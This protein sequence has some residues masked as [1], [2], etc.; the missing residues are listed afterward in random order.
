MCFGFKPATK[1]NSYHQLYL[2][3]TQYRGKSVSIDPDYIPVPL[4]EKANIFW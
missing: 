4:I 3:N 1:G 2:L